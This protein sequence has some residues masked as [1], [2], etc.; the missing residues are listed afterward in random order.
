MWTLFFFFFFFWDGKTNR[1]RSTRSRPQWKRGICLGVILRSD[2][3]LIPVIK[4]QTQ[5]IH[6]TSQSVKTTGIFIA[7]EEVRA[8]SG[9]TLP[10]TYLKNIIF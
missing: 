8:Q 6:I 3:C 2:G 7:Q 5:F 9:Q 10:F 4:F 1:G